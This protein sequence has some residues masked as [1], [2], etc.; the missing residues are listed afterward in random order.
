MNLL[1]L[2]VSVV[3]AAEVIVSPIPED[4]PELTH[5]IIQ[6]PSRSFG[7][8]T[9]FTNTQSVVL[10]ASTDK[11]IIPALKDVPAPAVQEQVTHRARKNAFTIAVIGDSMVDTLGPGVPQLNNKLTQIYPGTSFQILN[12]GVGSTNIEYGITRLTNAY[13]Y[14]GKH[15]PSLISQKPDIVVIESFGYNPLSSDNGELDQHWLKL[16]QA[17]DT[18]RNNL[19]DSKIVIAATIA[20]NWD[21][22]GDGAPGISF[23]QQ[24]KR[25][26]VTRIKSYLENTVKFAQSQHLPI[27][28]AYHASLDGN[29]NGRINLINAGDH[30]HYSDSGRALFAQKVADSILANRLLE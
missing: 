3:Y 19:P 21:V 22:F 29:G 10:G 28:D 11:A 6:Q 17:V 20:P 13:D 12:Y 15:I 9:P 7:S 14:L 30:I 25:E 4:V 1:S 26:R 18:V 5:V 16:S 24:D 2:F 23:S 27:A 8:L